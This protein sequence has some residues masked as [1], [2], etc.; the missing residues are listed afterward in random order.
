MSM[1]TCPCRKNSRIWGSM[2][3]Y[4]SVYYWKRGEGFWWI[5]RHFHHWRLWSNFHWCVIVYKWQNQFIEWSGVSAAQTENF[6]F[7]SIFFTLTLYHSAPY[8]PFSY[9]KVPFQQTEISSQSHK[10]QELIM[11]SLIVLFKGQSQANITMSM[12]Y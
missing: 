12:S 7:T 6:Y 4:N 11:A 3:T 1:T 5:L 10:S 2:D 9:W 8:F